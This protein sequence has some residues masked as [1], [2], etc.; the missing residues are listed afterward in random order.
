MA[1][2]ECI[3]PAKPDGSPRH[4]EGDTVTLRETLGFVQATTVRN[5][6]ALMTGEDHITASD[7]LAGLTET[8]L[9]VGIESWTLVDAKGKPVPVTRGNIVDLLLSHPLVAMKVGDEADELYSGAVVLPL[10]GMASGSLPSTPVDGSTSA[11]TDSPKQPPKPSKPS[12]TTTTRTGVTDRTTASL[13]G[14]SN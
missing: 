7:I 3:C 8:Y 6:M 11:Q 5:R 2:I 9:F 10:L 12:S 4:P 14:V 1:E 13:A